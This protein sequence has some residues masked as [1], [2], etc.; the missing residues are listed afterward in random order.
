M[1]GTL[2]P[3][4]PSR[5][6]DVD[7]DV[8]VVGAGLAGLSAAWDLSEH[9]W[10]VTVLEGADRVG[11][12]ARS[13]RAGTETIDLGAEWVGRAHRRVLALARTFGVRTEPARN[14]GETTIWRLPSG[15]HVGR[16]PPPGTRRDLARMMVAAA[17]QSRGL[18]VR[19]PWTYAHAERLDA[20]SAGEWLRRLGT[21]ADTM[22][23]LDCMFGSLASARLDSL[24]VLHLLWWARLAGGPLRSLRTTFQYRFT[25]GAQEL[26]R[27][28]AARLPDV[29]L[30]SPVRRIDHD[31]DHAD[32]HT[33]SDILRARHVVVAV[34]VSGAQSIRFTPAIPQLRE[35]ATLSVGPGTKVAALLPP[36]PAPQRAVI[37]GQILAGA[38]RRGR[39]VTGF[40]N[41]A[42]HPTPAAMIE[43][44]AGAFGV[45]ASDLSF[46]LVYSWADHPFIPGCDLALRPGEVTGLASRL[47]LATG[48]LVF[49]S[50]ERS[51]W[52]NNL[53]GA[54]ESGQAAAALIRTRAP[55]ADAL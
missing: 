15:E 6:A 11:G 31:T 19:H 23:L 37:G 32:I 9:G 26:P 22:Y 46:A 12:R 55:D 4:V 48:V 44:L 40:A 33:D 5:S 29:R 52:P 16:M 8:A 51:T 28:I 30:S 20:V 34:P 35:E 1:A 38:W 54:V 21:G 13:V 17:H 18:D 27:R 2:E 43:D 53:E 24:S 3:A 50:A 49:A 36:S 10:S 45:K 14:L 42:G 25:D 7:V 39:R 41:L 47:R